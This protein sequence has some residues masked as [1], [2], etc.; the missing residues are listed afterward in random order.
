MVFGGYI[1]IKTDFKKPFSIGE[2]AGKLFFSSFND[3]NKI[4][5]ENYFK[6]YPIEIKA[7]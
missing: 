1:K 4:D 5:W 2:F 3:K 6:D 7:N